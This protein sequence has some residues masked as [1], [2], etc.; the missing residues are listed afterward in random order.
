MRALVA[1]GPI[2]AGFDEARVRATAR[3]LVNKRRQSLAR[4]WPSLVKAIGA[5]YAE[6]FTKYAQAHPMPV[7]ATPRGDGR[8]FLRWLESQ[9][10]L[11]DALR[12]EAMAFDL[13]FASTPRGLSRRG[14]FGLKVTR[15]P[16]SR[17]LVVAWRLPWLGERWWGVPRM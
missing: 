10:P 13:R 11:S 12:L 7:C 5:S 3:S 6:T 1:Q 17:A 15:L 4:I 14:R 9:Q 8:A 2:P 16:Q